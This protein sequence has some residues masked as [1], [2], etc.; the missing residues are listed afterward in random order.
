MNK[1]KQLWALFKFQTSINPFIWFMP[2]AFSFPLL[3][4]FISTYQPSLSSSISNNNL[5]FVIFLSVMVIAPD[6]FYT[7]ATQNVWASGTEFL[8]T[9]ATDRRVIY[10]AKSAFAYLLILIVPLALFLLT[11]KNPVLKTT[12]YS[13]TF[14]EECVSKLPGTML[15]KDTDDRTDQLAIPNGRAL[16]DSWI[17]WT[18]LLAAIASQILLCIIYPLKYA[19]YL[20]W[21]I[22]F[23]V[24]FVPIFMIESSIHDDKLSPTEKLFFLYATHQPFAWL[25]MILALVLTQF[26]CERRFARMEQ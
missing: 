7:S 21:G 24:L 5:F 4:K 16:V 22:Y 12:E 13:K 3:Q 17:I 19:R 1:T 9:R 23:A 10:R 6:I 26:W 8:L 20:F 18:F 11:P 25:S 2:L 14:R 15:I